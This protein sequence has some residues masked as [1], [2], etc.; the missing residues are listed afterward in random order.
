[1]G[2][3]G[4]VFVDQSYWQSAI[5]AKP[6]SAH[7][8][9]LMGGLCWFAIPFAL[10][11]S[12]GLA[13]VAMQ[14]P[15]TAKEAGDGLV[16]PAVMM[17][18]FGEGGAIAISILLFMAITSTGSG[19]CMAVSS[20]VAYDVWKVYIRPNASG[21]EILIVSKVAVVV[22]GTSMGGFA[23]AL[24]YMGIN[25]GWVYLFMG[26]VIG[27]AVYPLWNLLM[28]KQANA[29]GAVVA[30]W[31]GMG[32]SFMT[33]LITAKAMFGELTVD[34]LGKNEP[35]LAGNCVALLAGCSIHV[36]MSLIWPQNYD[37]KSMNDIAMLEHDESGLDPEDYT[38]DKLK[39]AYRWIMRWG[40]GFTIIMV[41]LWPCASLPAKVFTKEYFAFWVLISLVWGF[42]ASAAVIVMPIAESLDNL[43]N[44][45]YILTGLKMFKAEEKTPPPAPDKST[46]V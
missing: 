21:K 35:M 28:W 43:Y 37:W 33:W 30:A 20:L 9:Y 25:L 6:A 44:D 27:S 13:S 19:E 2:N 3:F 39:E 45:M 41:I 22:F 5:A 31:L 10:A 38:E 40:F 17:H 32:L 42:A 24:N 4:T 7:K 26:I 16:P 18:M 15:I 11:T 29:S 14:L 34:T 12:L 46:K 36:I 23:V 1:V 8:G